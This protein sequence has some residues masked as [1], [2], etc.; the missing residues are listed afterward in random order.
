MN[1]LGGEQADFT[2]PAIPTGFASIDR[3]LGGG[4]LPRGR[5]VEL[6]GEIGSGKTSLALHWIATAQAAGFS[7][8]FVDADHCLDQGWAAACGVRL[9]S[10][11]LVRPDCGWQAL[12]M[13]EQLALSRTVDLV[14]LDSAAALGADEGLQALFEHMGRDCEEE[15]L[16]QALRRLRFVAER[17]RI[18]LLVLNP[19]V[20]EA[21]GW[22]E[23]TA[24]GR[25]LTLQ[26]AVSI[27]LTAISESLSEPGWRHLHLITVKNKLAE[28]Y[29]EAALEQRGASLRELG[30]KVAAGEGVR[31]VAAKT[32]LA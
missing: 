3:L 26:A 9:S 21:G 11:V 29:L 5:I 1:P 28:P 16:H 13:I 24:A 23:R 19:L 25:A 30:R 10:L 8:V 6:Y 22:P 20:E 31:L 17:S 15:F 2:T 27:R 18:S 7:A 4:G 14:V 12:A 32:Y